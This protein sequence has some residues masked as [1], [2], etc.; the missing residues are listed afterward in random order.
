MFLTLW[1]AIQANG[2]RHRVPLIAVSAA[3]VLA[4]QVLFLAD[5]HRYTSDFL[6]AVADSARNV[7][8]GATVL[9]VDLRQEQLLR[10]DA[11]KH[12]AMAVFPRTVVHLQN[13]EAATDY[14]PVQYRLSGRVPEASPETA[15]N[16]RP[17]YILFYGPRDAPQSYDAVLKDYRLLPPAAPFFSRIYERASTAR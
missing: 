11:A 6:A 13:Y 7:R 9:A 10:V 5:Y 17:D 8:P 3:I 16:L 14:F 12:A 15:A 1:A 2:W 4:G